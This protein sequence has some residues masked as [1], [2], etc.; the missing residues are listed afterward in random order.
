MPITRRAFLPATASMLAAPALAA[1]QMLGEQSPPLVLGPGVT[2]VTANMVVKVDLML[3]PGAVIEVAAGRTLTLLGGLIAPL[4]HIFT[5]PG[6]VDLG[7]SRI[8][9]A[10]PEWWGAAPGDGGRDSLPALQACL[11]S[12]PAMRLL[13]ADYYISNTFV[14]ERGFCS[15]TGAGFRGTQPGDGT[16]LIVTNG[17]ADVMRVGPETSPGGV[18]A[19]PQN[20]AVRSLALSRSVVPDTAGGR[21]PAGL[22]AQFL[23][24]AD[25]REISA[26]EH[27]AGFVARGLVRS[28]LTDC[29]AFRSM[30]GAQSGQLWRGFLLDG[31]RDIGLAGGNA[32]I[33]LRGCNATIGGAPALADPVGLQIEGAFADTFITEFETSGVPTG[34]RIDGKTAL[35]GARARHGHIDLHLVLPIIDQCASVGID[36]LDTSPDALIDVIDP[37]VAVA[38]G[39]KAALRLENMRGLATITGGQLAGAV[40]LAAGGRAV[41]L[42]ASASSGLQVGGLKILEHAR[43]AA[44]TG[45]SGFALR[46]AI[47]NPSSRPGAS[48]I[49]LRDCE[50]G[51]A[52]VLI[53]GQNSAFAS[54]VRVEGSAKRLRIDATTISPGAVGDAGKRVTLGDR[55]LA[56]PSRI[57]DLAVVGV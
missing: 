40:N 44:L 55:P 49:V 30:T 39:A 31:A 46:L 53:S 6:R 41:G 35:I 21:M 13:A 37:Y 18:N 56:V 54:G 42:L 20:I 33:F 22:R 29:V 47:A 9:S 10:H 1:P 12:H 3:Q 4:G 32:S 15:I 26:F 14:V 23:L 17:T 28:T 16:R 48:A 57:G 27:G 50:G 34:I 43:P 24:F 36:I 52:D 51:T 19:F 7:R 2:R 5:G 38:P 8:A 11:R 45:C 25:F